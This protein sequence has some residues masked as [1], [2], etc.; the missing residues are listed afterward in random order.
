MLKW[1][2]GRPCSCVKMSVIY[3]MCG[4]VD[5]KVDWYIGEKT[6]RDGLVRRTKSLGVVRWSRS[7][8]NGLQRMVLTDGDKLDGLKRNWFWYTLDCFGGGDEEE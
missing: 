5:N 6:I 8:A 4:T 1:C 3:C 2:D 7:S